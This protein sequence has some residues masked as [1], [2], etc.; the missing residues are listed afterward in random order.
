MGIGNT[1][2]STAIAALLTGRPVAE[3]AGRGTGIDDARLARKIT[4][5]EEAI[6]MNRPNPSDGVDV[7]SRI[8]GFEIGGLAGLILGAA[9]ARIPVVIDGV[10]S[11]AAALIAFLLEPRLSG[12]MFSAHRS[13]EKA[14]GAMLEHMGL[15]PILDLQMRLGEGT[16]AALA[17]PLIEAGVKV[18]RE[19]A[20][21]EEAGVSEG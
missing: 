4:V 3:L 13:V 18:I 8:G 15:E 1:T 9:E 19:M 16:G 10:I 7:L 11:T 2:P 14:Q 12:F 20:T 17:M 5:I 21:F 6:A